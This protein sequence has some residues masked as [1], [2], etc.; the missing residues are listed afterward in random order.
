MSKATLPLLL[1]LPW[2]VCSPTCLAG[3]PEPSSPLQFSID[4]VTRAD[5]C[6]YMLQSTRDASTED[7]A[8]LADFHAQRF[9]SWTPDLEALDDQTRRLV[10][11]NRQTYLQTLDDIE[12][13]RQ[14]LR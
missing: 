14:Q 7:C 12:G 3:D 10:Q 9:R 1:I 8:T 13:E 11:R 2:G 4:A 5:N 6:L